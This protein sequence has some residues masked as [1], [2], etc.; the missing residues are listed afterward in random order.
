MAFE[1]IG[2]EKGVPFPDQADCR[3]SVAIF[4]VPH[5]YQ[6]DRRLLSDF[7]I[8]LAFFAGVAMGQTGGLPAGTAGG[9]RTG[10]YHLAAGAFVP[11]GV[12]AGEADRGIQADALVFPGG[13]PDC[14]PGRAGRNVHVGSD[15][16]GGSDEDHGDHLYGPG[17]RIPHP[18][19]GH[20][21][22]RGGVL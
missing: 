17:S 1:R 5:I 18:Q 3:G 6:P 11:Q 8:D 19:G 4:H 16:A 14:P 20:G 12:Q 2:Y 13:R 7:H 21:Q 10:L 9:L 22:G 15:W